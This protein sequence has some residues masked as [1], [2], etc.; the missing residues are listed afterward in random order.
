MPVASPRAIFVVLFA[1]NCVLW[2]SSRYGQVS[3][4]SLL[5]GENS[6]VKRISLELLNSSTPDDAA[7]DQCRPLAFPTIEQC[8]HVQEHCHLPPTFLAI[9][10]LPHYFC[11]EPT[12]RP[13]VF[14]ALIVWLVF[15]FSTLG[16][17]ASDFFTPNLAT[18]AQLLGLDENVA[19]VT[20][21]AFGNGSPDVFSTFSAMRANSGSLAI[22]ELLGAASFIVSC[23]VGSMCIIK[24]FQ[25]R[26]PLYFLRD[27]GFMFTAV[28]LLLVILW[29]GSIRLW[30]AAVMIALYVIYV[31]VVVLGSWWE[32]R[33]ERRR[34]H[35]AMVRSEY[36]D[37]DI[38][39][40]LQERYTDY[41]SP[42]T[43]HM[44]TLVAPSPTRARAISAPGAPPRLQTD[45]PPRSHSRTP[46]PTPSPG[47]RA[48]PSF[49]LV[50]ALEFRQVVASLQHEAAGSSLN[51]F[52]S[53]FTPY[54]GGHYNSLRSR[55]RTLSREVDPWDAALGLPLDERSRPRLVVTPVSHGDT[56][57]EEPEEMDGST[58]DGQSRRGT[59]MPS[60]SRT[61]ASPTDTDADTESQNF[62]PPTRKQRIIYAL[63]RT[64]HTLF[65]SLQRFRGKTVLGQIASVF[66]APAVML[67]TLTL[68]VV[69][70]PY[71]SHHHS[72]EKTPDEEP[73]LID[74]E[75]EGIERILIAEEEVEEE[76]HGM[77][78]NKWLTAAQCTC[79]PLFGAA[80]LFGGNKHQTW[81]LLSA[82]IVGFAASVLVALFVENGE[83]PSF[84]MTRCSMGFIVA[85]VW[86]MA[87]ADEVVKVLQTFGFIFGLSD[88]IIGLTI[89]AVGNSLADL[90]ANMSVAVFAPIMGFSACFGGPMLN[91]LLGVGISG[92]YITHNTGEPYS[93]QFGST[94][95]V[96]TIGL[97]ILLAATLV[98][99]PLNG[100]H[101]TRT[102]GIILIASYTLIM[103]INVVVEVK[104]IY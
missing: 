92:S 24:P 89:F 87:I 72:R 35:E 6:L 46:S 81:A 29:D 103:A 56:L 65:P 40:P 36:A 52:D 76:M 51:V 73:N 99:V 82:G 50:G 91:I 100:Y 54:A 59:S 60:I 57:T 80:V 13:L 63:G 32:R 49:S 98:V 22:G 61:P 69:V 95:L 90:V 23:V 15:L 5:H 28:S 66:A 10:Y 102:W 86:I 67:L 58:I 18:I 25:L 78:Y 11:T 19:G 26:Q 33:L 64:Y 9:R 7:E 77:S 84:R 104:H 16:I 48:M 47:L 38:S 41:P 83:H 42:S 2:S 45:L 30:E 62:Q 93:L 39:S 74:F 43:S 94:L 44:P 101:L 75:E 97:L 14:T 17:S 96:S 12:L 1:L 70:T 68:P 53:P 55:S 71:Q 31:V 4:N 21:L 85:V 88:A 34:A 27:V 3:H 8:A 79:G 37:S 20:F